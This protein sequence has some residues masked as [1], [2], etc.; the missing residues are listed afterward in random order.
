MKMTQ[1]DAARFLGVNEKTI[2]RR[3]DYW[4]KKAALKNVRFRKKLERSLVSE[5]QFDDLI[6]KEKTKLKPLSITVA[7]DAKRRFI[8]QANVS[9]IPAFGH[10]AKISR[11]K[12]GYRKSTFL[13]SL[14][15]TF[16]NIE[17]IVHPH[18]EIRSDEH[19]SYEA[20]VRKFF[21]E[22]KYRQF[23]SERGCIAGQGELKKVKF[24]PIFNINHTMAMLRAGI[25]TLVRRSW[26]VTQDVSRLQSHLE[27][28][29]YYYNQYYLRKLGPLK[30]G[31]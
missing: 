12:Y 15:K 21:P 1:K 8:L 24:D 11:A 23:R 7:V 26:A 22:S 27:I 6:T 16:V 25:A 9:Q 18:C 3:F 31:G 4:G 14:D 29:M 17:P 28:F 13:E 19:K 5:L 10:L 20:F 2:S 30:G